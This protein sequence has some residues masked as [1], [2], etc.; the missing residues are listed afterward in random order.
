MVDI[1]TDKEFWALVFLAALAGGSN[2]TI[3]DAAR[4]ADRALILW[5]D[6]MG[7]TDE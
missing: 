6:T 1:K 4:K 5:K 2:V 3:D 7:A